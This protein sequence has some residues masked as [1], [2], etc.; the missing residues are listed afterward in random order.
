MRRN[1]QLLFATLFC[2]AACGGRQMG[3]GEC[4]F[5]DPDKMIVLKSQK[6]S[7]MSVMHHDSEPD[8]LYFVYSG[9]AG[10]IRVDLNTG[11][12]SYESVMSGGANGEP[13]PPGWHYFATADRISPAAPPIIRSGL[14]RVVFRGTKTT[15]PAIGHYFGDKRPRLFRKPLFNG[16]RQ[17][18]YGNHVLVEQELKD[19]DHVPSLAMRTHVEMDGDR[20]ACLCVDNAS[21]IGIFRRGLLDAASASK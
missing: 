2:L 11:A 13:P 9:P 8:A 14:L 20:I 16:T 7:L 10:A 5:H 19:Y 3:T 12:E 17:V 21:R 1:A 4:R 15:V 6:I 18:V